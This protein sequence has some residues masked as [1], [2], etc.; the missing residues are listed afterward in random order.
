MLDF[1][2]IL[3]NLKTKTPSVH[4]ITNYVTAN[5]CANILLA[6]GASPVM[7]YSAEESAEITSRSDALLLNLGTMKPHTPEAMQK[8]GL[9]ANRDGKP[10][11]FDPVGVGSS[12]FRSR[13]AKR[14]FNDIKISL[15]RANI[16]EVK[17]LLNFSH[18]N[19]GVDADK[20]DKVTSSNLAENIRLVKTLAKQTNAITAATGDCDLISDG[21]TTYIIKN[22]HAMMSRITGAGCMLSSLSAAFLASNQDFPLEAAAAAVCCFGICGELAF[23]DGI[24]SGSYRINLID[25]VFKL[26]SKKVKEKANYE[27]S[28]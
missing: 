23:K 19:S 15:I 28:A 4:C 11:I 24:G 26:N 21:E 14:L 25:E 12:E 22:G 13:T 17:A 16:S 20:A 27:I 18:K 1:D 8:S 2:K 9:Q 3:L 7:A 5:D 10:V 6:C